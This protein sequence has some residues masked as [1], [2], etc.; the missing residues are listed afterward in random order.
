MFFPVSHIKITRAI[1]FANYY[2]LDYLHHLYLNLNRVASRL[3][4]S[5]CW[6][7]GL[8]TLVP[9]CVTTF[10]NAKL[11]FGAGTRLRVESSKL[12]NDLQEMQTV[13][14]TFLP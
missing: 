12:F 13:N 14:S 1:L 3:S 7:L 2:Y 5:C 10:G 6:S 4:S 9:H 11:I 8:C